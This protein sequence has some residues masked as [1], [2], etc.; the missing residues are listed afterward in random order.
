MRVRVRVRVNPNPHP[1][2]NQATTFDLAHLCLFALLGL[3]A[4]LAAAALLRLVKG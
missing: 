1:N 3:A 2:P 4:A